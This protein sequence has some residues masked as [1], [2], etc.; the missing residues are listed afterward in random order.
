MP[1]PTDAGSFAQAMYGQMAPLQNAEAQTGWA[2]LIFLGAIGQTLQDLDYLA[3]AP[4]KNLPVWFNLVDLDA[5]P[6]NA[7][8]WL[9]LF[10]GVRVSPGNTPSQQRQQIRDKIGWGRG[11][12]TAI[13]AAIRPYLTG[14]KTITILERDTGPYHLEV[15]TY[16]TESPAV[17]P[18]RT[19]A[20]AALQAAKPAGLVLFWNIIAGS[21]TGGTYATLYAGYNAYS[22]I[23]TTFTTYGDIP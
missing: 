20:A 13:A 17:G 15:D 4:S 11:R 8:P 12:P 6:D 21:P 1:A 16:S 10:V 18:I 5:I 7:V 19:A 14:T 2:L 23:Y 22:D 9:G 3:H